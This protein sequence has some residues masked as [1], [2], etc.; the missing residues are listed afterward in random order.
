MLPLIHGGL[1]DACASWPLLSTVLKRCVNCFELMWQLFQMKFD[2]MR[3]LFSKEVVT[4]FKCF[5]IMCQL[6]SIIGHLWVG[7]H[8]HYDVPW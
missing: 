5:H 8:V 2:M 6:S 4:V 1:K 7:H 3:Q